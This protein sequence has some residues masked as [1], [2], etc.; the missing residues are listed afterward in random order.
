LTRGRS[1]AIL[2]ESY[3]SK[4]MQNELKVGDRLGVKTRNGSFLVFEVK[5]VTRTL[6]YVEVVNSTWPSGEWKV[7]R[8]IKQNNGRKY[9]NWYGI[10]PCAVGTS[11]ML[12]LYDEECGNL[13]KGRRTTIALKYGVEKLEK[14]IRNLPASDGVDRENAVLKLISLMEELNLDVEPVK[15]RLAGEK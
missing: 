5:R 8:E 12:Y 9:A 14:T 7:K 3:K 1:G 4:E 2:R 15:Q 11:S 13:E 10:I 6:A